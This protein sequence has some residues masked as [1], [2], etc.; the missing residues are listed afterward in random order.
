V[1]SGGPAAA[2]DPHRSRHADRHQAENEARSRASAALEEERIAALGPVVDVALACVEYFPTREQRDTAGSKRDA[3]N[4]LTR[5]VISNTALASTPLALLTVGQLAGLKLDKRT[6]ND[7]RAALNMA[8]KRHRDV[9]PPT[10]RDVIRDGLASSHGPA[11]APRGERA[12]LPDSDVR[13]LID[14]GWAVDEEGGW[15][16]ALVRLVM[17]LAATGARFSQVVRMRVADVQPAQARLMIP[18]SRKGGGVKASSHVAVRVG[19]DVLA[20]LAPAI[21]GRLGHELLFMRPSWRLA[22][23]LAWERGEESRPWGESNELRRPWAAIVARAGLPSTVTPYALRHSSIC[24]ALKAGL[25]VQLVARLHDTSAAMIEANYS[26]Q[27]VS[28]MDELAERAIIPL[29][30]PAATPIAAVKR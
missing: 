5:H 16:G 24:R 21:A 22:V 2:C 29:T 9:L 23:G 6:K 4:R 8:A 14:S 3:R 17:V 20:A 18:T 1:S 27:I 15:A 12:G 28:L 11:R 25:P 7:F 30:S 10:L 19:P 13:R 26:A